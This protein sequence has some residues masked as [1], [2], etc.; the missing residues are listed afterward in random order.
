MTARDDTHTTRRDFTPRYSPHHPIPTISK[1]R[2]EKAHRGEAH[3]ALAADSEEPTWAEK[4]ATAAK[5]YWTG[6]SSQSAK[7]AD[8]GSQQHYQSRNKN[9]AQHRDDPDAHDDDHDESTDTQHNY[10]GSES[11]DEEED[12][13][14]ELTEDTS[15]SMVSGRTPKEKRKKMKRRTEDPTERTVTDPVTHLPITIHDFTNKDLKNVP[16][17]EDPPNSTKRCSTGA[18]AKEKDH[19]Q[20]QA[21]ADESEQYHSGIEAMFPPPSFENTRNEL[22]KIYQNATTIVLGLVVG[23][24]LVALTAARVS[25]VNHH[26]AVSTALIFILGIGVL[27]ILGMRSWIENKVDAVWNTEVW[28]AERQNGKGLAKSE[29]PE[30]TQWLNSLLAA[31]WPLVNP[32]LFTSLADTL[33]DVMQASLPKL[34]RMVSV[35]DLGQGSEAIRI[36]G[37]RWLPTGAAAMSVSNKGKLKR[38]A[39]PKSSDR[40]VPG[41]G[42]VQNN[43]EGK[44]QADKE[45]D[46]ANSQEDE[47]IAEG[48]EA[49][50][51][52][53]C[54]TGDF[55]NLEV[56]FAYRSRTVNKG[57][58]D[59]A[60]NAHLYLAFYLPGNIKFPVWVELEG[61]VGTVRAR[62]QLTPDPPFFSLCTLTFLG[63]P[64]VD[65]SCVPLTRRGLDIMDIPLISNFVQSAVD[66]AMAEYVAPKS[67]TL[68]LKDMLMGDDFKKDT[69]ARGVIV[70]HIKRAFG[71]KEGDFD[72]LWKKG[73]T[74]G[75]ISIGWAKF[76][77]PL[78]STRIIEADME[79]CWDETSFVLVT[80]DELNVDER[81]RVQLWDSD[82]TTADDDLGR[83]EVDIKQLMRDPRSNGKMMDRLDGFRALEAGKRMPGKLEWSVGYFSKTR[84]LDSQLAEQA[85]DPTIRTL[86]DL[87]KQ[88]DDESEKKLREAKRDESLELEQQKAQTLKERQDQLIVASRPPSEYPSGILSVTIHQI[89]GLEL[90]RLNKPSNDSSDI[91]EEENGEDLPSSYCTIVMNHRKVYRT[92]TKPKNAQPFFNAGCERFIGDWRETDIHISVRDARVHEDD[93]LLGVIYLPLSKVLAK[94]SQVN[95]F[96]PLAG[97]IGYGRARISMVFR[98]IKLQAP[99]PALGWDYGTLLVAPQTVSTH[100]PEDYKHHRSKM[101]PTS[102]PIEAPDSEFAASSQPKASIPTDNSHDPLTFRTHGSRPLSLPV[103]RRHRT[104]LTITIRPR[105]THLHSLSHA[106]SSSSKA[107]N[108]VFGVTYLK[109]I[110]D[111]EDADVRIGVYGGRDA[112]KVYERVKK[113]VCDIDEMLRTGRVSGDGIEKDAEDESANDGKSGED[114]GGRVPRL[115]KMGEIVLTLRFVPGLSRAHRSLARRDVDVAHVMQ[116]LEAVD[117]CDGATV[118]AV[119][120]NVGAGIATP[121]T[122]TR[123]SRSSSETS[124]GEEDGSRGLS[125]GDQDGLSDSKRTAASDGDLDL[126]SLTPTSRSAENDTAFNDAPSLVRSDS[127]Y[128]TGSTSSSSSSS[129]SSTNLSTD[130]HRGLGAATKEYKRTR[131]SQHRRHRGLM[132][133]KGPRTVKWL[134]HKVEHGGMKVKG[135]LGRKEKSGGIESEA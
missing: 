85:A 54:A 115:T 18:G 22:T 46:P 88:V 96:F 86:G 129:S 111:N 109:D 135:A 116:V 51:G 100:L 40:T 12:Y 106:L 105:S 118:E 69:S 95:A 55:V 102:S 76:N 7:D 36:L 80:P 99:R 44:D 119:Q 59:R 90:E 57:I 101:H 42:E 87:R 89:T 114:D 26:F 32:D 126:D 3:S 35:E 37:V 24:L 13:G 25:S 62:L 73:S 38:D 112:E 34:V 121:S 132:Q 92:R 27:A 72:F 1:Y 60:K 45:Q 97:G 58:K 103:A 31:I 6:E 133:W 64:K 70:V 125:R 81:L 39:D 5:N 104:P 71:I 61:F 41:Q 108:F 48:M 134:G 77:K 4:T 124:D 82:R 113:N 128:S 98:A 49:E 122:T 16:E 9:H 43:T 15:E 127:S 21:E 78:W 10:D 20:L 91:E 120:G 107:E 110:A 93:P 56:A 131:K 11:G 75:Y 28:E 33:E 117:D 123:N 47:N 52:M 30:S 63:Q 94:R 65:V 84:I 8:D 2:E 67:L 53:L 66:A 79:P 17:N 130:G 23:M 29:T 83:I 19:D 50:E 14:G 68:D 74:D